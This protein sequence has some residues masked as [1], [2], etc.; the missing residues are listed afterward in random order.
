MS[1]IDLSN[2]ITTATVDVRSAWLS[3]INW[4]QAVGVGASLLV[5]T[6]GGKVNIPLE[7]QAGIVVAIQ[8]LCGV[9]TWALKT[10]GH[11]TVTASQAAK[12]K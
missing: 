3:K 11:P 12:V 7:Q 10:F 1:N 5:L 4:T 8:A 9:I 6:T 2:T